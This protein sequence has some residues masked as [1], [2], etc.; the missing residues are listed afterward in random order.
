MRS[1]SA[2]YES[3]AGIACGAALAGEPRPRRVLRARAAAL[4]DGF[5]WPLRLSHYLGMLNPLWSAHARQARLDDVITETDDAHTLVLRPGRGWRRHRAGQFVALGVTVD[6]ARHT[7]TYSISSAPEVDDGRVAVTVQAIPGGRVSQ[8]L[9]RATSPGAYVTLGLPQGDFVLPEASPVRPLFVT[10][11][12][13]ITPVMS[14]LR[15]FAARGPLPDVVHLHYAPHAGRVIFAAELAQLA[16][17]HPRYRLHV[18]ETRT[19]GDR[20]LRRFS[21][22]ALERQ[23]PDWAERDVYAC[24]PESLLDAVEG[25]WRAV[26][27]AARLRVE[28]FRARSVAPPEGV[29]GGHVR[30]SRSGRETLADGATPLLRVAEDAGLQPAHGCRIGICHT[31]TARLVSGCVRDVRS[32]AITDE[33]GTAIQLCVSAASGDVEVEV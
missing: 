6:G 1:S 30:F 4:V 18:V 17:E 12:S 19:N 32:N 11:G 20:T 2:T 5:A 24:G 14:M 22:A 33:P 31:C 3:S 8:H 26:G 9:V 13:G 28:R 15:S 21:H 29:R 25:H 10:A 23:C 16:R 7:R 27:L